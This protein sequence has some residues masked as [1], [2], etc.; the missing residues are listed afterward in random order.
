MKE[1]TLAATVENIA[2]VT[3]FVNAELE[4]ADCPMK[5]QMQINI[6]IDE[7]F[8][9]IA[10]YAYTPKT[11]TATVRF[12]LKQDPRTAELT[13]FDSGVPYNP[14]EKEDPDT[15]LSAEEREIGG[16]GIFLIKKTMDAVEYV[17]ENGQNVLTVR[18]QF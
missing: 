13:F 12:A 9:N 15:T 11:G 5:A 16:L 6:A 17:R 10:Q 8:T 7:I 3:D 1:L 14:L 4:A 2:V 18:K